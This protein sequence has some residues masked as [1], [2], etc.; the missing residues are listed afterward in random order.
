[1]T[2]QKQ[3]SWDFCQIADS[4]LNKCKS[5]TPP[6]FNNPE[7]LLSATGKTKI[8]TKNFSK[9]SNLDESGIS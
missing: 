7:L 5:G 3:V 4:V 1:M 9:S 6:L 2:S 8:F